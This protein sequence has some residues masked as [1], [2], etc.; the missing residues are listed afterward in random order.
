M[1]ADQDLASL[2]AQAH[3]VFTLD[4]ARTVELTRR[5]IRR[6]V[7]ERWQTI[8]EGVF[9]AAGAPAT[10]RGDLLAATLAAGAGSAISHRA[11]GRIY[12]MPGGRDDLVEL[13]CVRWR[14]TRKPGLVVHERR[15]LDE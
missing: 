6:R 12:E 2:A 1:T 9:R 8:H 3:G 7:R 11:S 10:W 15:R 14:R 4:D 13:S 5:Q